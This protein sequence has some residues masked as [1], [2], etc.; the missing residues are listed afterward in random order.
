MRPRKDAAGAARLDGDRVPAVERA[1]APCPPRPA[2]R[3]PRSPGDGWRFN[4][5]RIER[6]GGKANPEKDAVFAAWSKPSV[7]SFHDPAVFRDMV[8]LG[9]AR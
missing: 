7:K 9:A 5:F 3:R 8:F 2:S 6:P 4:V 1:S